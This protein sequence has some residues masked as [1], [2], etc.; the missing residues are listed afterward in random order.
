M[1]QSRTKHQI[2]YKTP[3]QRSSKEMTLTKI[4]EES[5]TD[6]KQSIPNRVKPPE[7]IRTSVVP[8]FEGDAKLF[9]TPVSGNVWQFQMWVK[10]DKKYIRKSTR[11][12]QLDEALEIGKE[13]FFDVKAKIKYEQPVF[14]KTIG[15]ISD[16]FL[17]QQEKE[18][19]LNKTFLRL[20]YIKGRIKHILSHVGQ[21]TLITSIPKSK[22]DDYFVTRKEESSDIT[23]DT[24]I[25][26]GTTVKRI[27]RFAKDKGYLGIQPLPEFPKIKSKINY[28]ESFDVDEWRIIYRFLRSNN[29]MKH[30]KQ[31]KQDERFF[32]R[33]FI[34][35]L[36]N[37]GIRFGEARKLLWKNIKPVGANEVRIKLSE[38]KTKNEK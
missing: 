33:Y 30:P 11:T 18:I 9:R 24:L 14:P 5:L 35:V 20:V 1:L 26:E 16:E 21:K 28:R 32:I 17:I 25:T 29:W 7:G 31:V 6:N 2:S 22:W 38:S 27:Y 23:N 15:E 3:L 37:T 19:G 4:V 8:I 36:I 34:L 13:F 12:R 10:E